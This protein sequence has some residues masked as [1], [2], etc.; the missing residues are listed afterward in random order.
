MKLGFLVR[1]S[2]IVL[3]SL[4][5]LTLET[6]SLAQA[7]AP[8]VV[9]KASG[10]IVTNEVTLTDVA[11]IELFTDLPEG[12]IFY[13]LDGSE[14]S[15]ASSRYDSSFRLTSSATLWAI[16][17]SGDFSQTA[18]TAARIDI[19][20]YFY[21]FILPDPAYSDPPG[22]FYPENT[23]VKVT[24]VDK[25]GWIFS[26]WA[27]SVNST[28]REIEVVLDSQKVLTTVVKG[29][30][31]TFTTPGGKIVLS[32]NMVESGGTI[33]VQAVPDDGYYFAAWGKGLVGNQ[34]PTE[35]FVRGPVLSV[36]NSPPEISAAFAPLPGNQPSLTL[37]WIDS[38][39]HLQSRNVPPTA[40][41][42]VSADLINWHNPDTSGVF[43]IVVP[44]TSLREFYRLVIP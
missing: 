29:E 42:Q 22:G 27:G 7:P 3:L 10:R 16:A 26:R 5:A 21:L 15:F 14:P 17:Y 11:D 9:I 4:F 34:N 36:G 44:T 1:K 8:S 2:C 33:S 43:D 35:L 24:A 40:F 28:N 6:N 32:T 25:N 23:V 37:R 20:H 13:T 39:L 30:I 31:K 41:L 12:Q 18:S 38:A 19:V